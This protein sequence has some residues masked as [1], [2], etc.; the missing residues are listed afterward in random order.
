MHGMFV[1]PNMKFQNFISRAMDK[2]IRGNDPVNG[3]CDKTIFFSFD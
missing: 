2:W 3:Y 1:H